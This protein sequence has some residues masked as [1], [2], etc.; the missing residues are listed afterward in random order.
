MAGQAGKPQEGLA[1]LEQAM[2][3]VEPDARNVL[4]SDLCRLRAELVVAASPEETAEAE[5][6]LQRARVIAE[7]ADARLLAL[8]AATSLARLHRQGSRLEE[9]R[10]VLEAA[11]QRMTEGFATADVRDAEALLREGA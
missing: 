1:L 3:G 7:K 8:R 10:Q 5:A 6:W 9:T 11:H 4:L 2:G